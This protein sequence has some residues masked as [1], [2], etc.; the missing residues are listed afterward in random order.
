MDPTCGIEAFLP[1]QDGYN[2]F[3]CIF[4]QRYLYRLELSSYKWDHFSYEDFIV[5]E[6]DTSGNVVH[7]TDLKVSESLRDV[8]P[9]VNIDDMYVFSDSEVAELEKVQKMEAKECV[10][11]TSVC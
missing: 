4:K 1:A 10:L 9:T 8:K 5:N 3:D 7:L 6:I 11:E 2:G